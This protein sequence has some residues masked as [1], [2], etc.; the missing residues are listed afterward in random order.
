M[1][2]VNYQKRTQQNVIDSH[3]TLIISHGKPTGGSAFTRRLV[4]IQ[5]R[6]LLHIDLAETSAFMA[7]A[8]IVNWIYQYGIEI[9]N[10]AG[11][12][13]RKDP[14]IYDDTVKLMKSTFYMSTVKAEMPDPG[15]H[16]PYNV[17]SGE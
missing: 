3:G 5:K 16:I 1:P 9:L 12:R 8:K 11:P 7:T 13:A 14:E 17:E 15:Q 2:T 4:K 10:V 6:P